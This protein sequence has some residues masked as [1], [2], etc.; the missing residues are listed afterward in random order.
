M[1]E[2]LFAAGGVVVLCLCWL[3]YFYVKH[4]FVKCKY[5]GKWLAYRKNLFHW[6]ESS[7]RVIGYHWEG[8]LAFPRVVYSKA[9]LNTNCPGCKKFIGLSVSIWMPEG[10]AIVSKISAKGSRCKHCDGSGKL[11]VQNLANN[12]QSIVAADAP[13]IRCVMCD[14]KGL[15]KD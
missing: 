8:D 13:C 10:A 3:L 4:T 12:A 11:C 14:G 7:A 9:Q 2:M 6:A 1:D 15:C 5:C